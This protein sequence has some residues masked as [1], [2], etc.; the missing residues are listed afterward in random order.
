MVLYDEDM[1]SR[2]INKGEEV[3]KF[4]HIVTVGSRKSSEVEKQ[5]CGLV[6]QN[7]AVPSFSHAIE[8]VLKVEKQNIG[9]EKNAR[10][11]RN[12]VGTGFWKHVVAVLLFIGI[13]YSGIQY[14][15]IT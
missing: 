15:G 10:C 13:D 2:N 12:F 8:R 6:L 3:L 4:G 14:S 5:N 9:I 1:N 7:H 11:V